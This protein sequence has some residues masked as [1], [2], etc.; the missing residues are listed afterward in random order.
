M[1]KFKKI[2]F[3]DMVRTV[4]YRTNVRRGLSQNKDKHS[5]TQT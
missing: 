2:K 5:K 1:L 3:S 4:G